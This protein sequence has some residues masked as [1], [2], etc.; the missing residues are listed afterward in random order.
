LNAAVRDAAER[1]QIVATGRGFRWRWAGGG[2]SL[3][4]VLWPIARSA[5]ELLASEER[6][7]VRVCDADTCAW[8]FVDRSRNRSRRW[9]SMDSC[10]NRAKARRH[11]SRKR[12]SSKRV[13][14]S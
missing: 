4:S 13:R 10:G 1:R 7:Q 6:S 9:C 8:L 14:S 3:E 5:G 2:T 11:Y 12:A